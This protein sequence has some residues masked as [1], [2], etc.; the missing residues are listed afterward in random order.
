M[1][2]TTNSVYDGTASLR[3][4]IGGTEELATWV[5]RMARWVEV[6]TE[7]LRERVRGMR[8]QALDLCLARDRL[9][10]VRFRPT[11]RAHLLS[12]FRNS[13]LRLMPTMP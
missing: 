11:D 1:A 9:P 6:L 13:R 12:L 3:I 10:K 7:S 5:M 8:K 4:T 2:P